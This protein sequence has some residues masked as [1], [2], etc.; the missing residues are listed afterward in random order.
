M[1]KKG[2]PSKDDAG[3]LES[4][5][6]KLAE[7]KVRTAR[8]AIV[9]SL[10]KPD[11]S[12]VRRL[13]RKWREVGPAMLVAAQ[14]KRRR[15][16]QEEA[17]RHARKATG[18][19]YH[20]GGGIDASALAE[21][22][23]ELRALATAAAA[24]LSG[25]GA[26]VNAMLA[27]ERA[28]MLPDARLRATIDCLASAGLG[29]QFA[30]E[31]AARQARELADCGGMTA[32]LAEARRSIEALGLESNATR[33]AIERQIEETRRAVGERFDRTDPLRRLLGH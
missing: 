2:R 14:E 23:H 20:Y 18:G 33:L 17:D 30:L 7:G 27:A 10:A 3:A 21:A 32:G 9:Q 15:Q 8:S 19:S 25:Y 24:G 5:A 13:Q 11:D 16:Q 28:S 4:V 26:T 6:A 22:Q 29:R 31:E 1:A 12:S